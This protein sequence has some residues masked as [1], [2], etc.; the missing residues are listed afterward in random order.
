MRKFTIL[1]SC[2]LFALITLLLTEPV[3]AQ[4]EVNTYRVVTKD[5]NTFVGTIVS[6]DAE[7]I[8][9][10]TENLGEITIQ[11]NR[12]K[13]MEVIDPKHLKEDGDYWFENP[14]STRYL[15]STNA[16]GLKKGEG[17]YQNTWIFFNN[18]N[19][20]VTNNFSMGAG[21][22]PTFLFGTGSTPFWLMPKVSI[23]VA[24]NNLH[25]A[26]GGLFGTVVGEGDSGFG[27]AYGV[28]TAG[29]RDNNVSLGIGYGYADGSW[30][31]IPLINLN[32][33]YRINKKL[34]LISE[35]Y[36]VSAGGET[37]GLLS[38]SLRWAPEN[39]AV[40]F[41]LI[42]PF[43]VGESIGGGFIGVPWLGVAIPFGK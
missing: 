12:I 31:D 13:S 1:I 9:L 26:A 36:F 15:F 3:I 16:M 39:L 28:V 20:G 34:Y 7:Q 17:Y 27:M 21:V 40:D 8:V 4:Q 29:N 42:R 35:N 23:P 43:V 33:M 38:G 32:G 19:Y 37:V 11:R 14:H 24:S 41:G 2:F 5:G 22:I 10:D 30:S 6:E 25:I 18:V